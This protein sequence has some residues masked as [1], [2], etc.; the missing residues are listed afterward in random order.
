[1]Q[2]LKF[3]IK[4]VREAGKLILKETKKPLHVW[5][6]SKDDL[7]TNADKKSEKFIIE[8][9]KKNFPNHAI[10]A[11]ENSFAHPGHKEKFYNAE[12]IWIIDPLD[13]TTNFAHHLPLFAVSIGLFKRTNKNPKKSGFLEG[14]VI[15]GVV[16][17]PVLDELFYA[18]KGKGAFLNGKK[19]KVSNTKKLEKSFLVTGIP[20]ERKEK[21]LPYVIE[22][23]KRSQALRRLGAATLDIC[24]V[25][26]GRF[27]G[28]WEFGLHAWDVAAAALI[29][30]EA[31]GKVTNTK[32]GLLD[33]TAGDI[34]ATNGNIHNEMKKY[35]T[36]C[37]RS[38]VG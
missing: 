16:Y 32:G 13:G 30:Q 1:M 17:A 36:L 10:L 26:C 2:I 4:T 18:E 21:N 14:E 15:A 23:I 37:A 3:A 38:S 22:M 31:G 19:I 8:K 20:P 5:E 35:L 6:K 7:V 27:D 12:Y 25:A 28:H 9:I 11:E 29:L 24:Y 33:L 34:L